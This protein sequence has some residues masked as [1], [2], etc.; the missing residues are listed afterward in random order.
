M[1]NWKLIYDNII[2]E[3]IN[4]NKNN[5]NNDFEYVEIFPYLKKNIFLTLKSNNQQIISS[6]QNKTMFTLKTENLNS[7]I[8]KRYSLKL[9]INIPIFNCSQIYNEFGYYNIYLNN[10][11]AMILNN[12]SDKYLLPIPNNI[13][14]CINLQKRIDRWENIQKYKFNN[15]KIERF[16]A[17][18]GR[19]GLGWEGCALS[20]MKLIL[21]AMENKLDYLIV[22]ED[23]FINIIHDN[24]WEIRLITIINWLILNKEK[25]DVFNGCPIGKL[26]IPLKIIDTEVGIVDLSGGYNTHFIIYNGL[27]YNKI[28]SWFKQYDPNYTYI[29]NNIFPNLNNNTPI[30]NHLLTIDL[31]LSNN[32]NMITCFPFLTNSNSDDS[33]IIGNFSQT[34]I[35]KMLLIKNLILEKKKNIIDNLIDKYKTNN[36]DNEIFN[37]LVKE[38]NEINFIDKFYSNPNEIQIN[39]YF[40]KKSQ[41][42]SNFIDT[43]NFIKNTEVLFGNKNINGN[44]DTIVII[45]SYN[46][47]SYLYSS[48]NSFL[49]FN[50]YEI[51]KI[52]I[53][54]YQNNKEKYDKIKTYYPN[55]FFEYS[56]EYDLKNISFIE[57]NYYFIFSDYWIFTCSFFIEISK[58]LITN[59]NY[60]III[61][62]RD[63]D[64]TDNK[65]ICND[66]FNINGIFFWEFKDLYENNIFNG[67]SEP[68]LLK[69]D[70]LLKLLDDKY[71]LRHLIIPGG[72]VKYIY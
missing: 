15:F 50:S 9:N 65:I 3:L 32:T 18:E 35:N 61:S 66:I 49:K 38:N 25:W 70:V 68:F 36:Y 5:K 4:Y 55:I 6:A 64:D 30:Y 22:A 41:I 28:L 60:D 52:I 71:K 45:L 8:E 1:I 19:T 34:N 58:I 62:I 57:S 44:S 7:Y 16:N 37:L 43:Y 56:L 72:F 53:I 40:N 29:N 42:I 10:I 13:I 33:D 21:N 63:I 23:D 24:L 31:W 46:Y 20:H 39:Q 11:N 67:K 59:I 47:W 12:I 48:V 26:N 27:S 51:K 54:D 69:N 14:F 17:I 2:I